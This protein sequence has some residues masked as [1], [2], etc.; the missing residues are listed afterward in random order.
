MYAQILPRLLHLSFTRGHAILS[1][2]PACL[3]ILYQIAPPSF[4]YSRTSAFPFILFPSIPTAPSQLHHPDLM[5]PSP[6]APT[7]GRAAPTPRLRCSRRGTRR[8]PGRPPQVLPRGA[9]DVCGGPGRGLRAGELQH[10]LAPHGRGGRR[11][12][13]YGRAR[14]RPLCRASSTAHTGR[15]HAREWEWEWD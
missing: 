2:Y 6:Q 9:V 15:A 12:H 14:Q 13:T 1:K 8:R 11:N 10:D 5:R 4:S 7:T 3:L